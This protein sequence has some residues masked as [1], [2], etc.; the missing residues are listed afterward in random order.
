M[1]ITY[2]QESVVT[3]MNQVEALAKLEWEEVQHNKEER[4][5]SPDWDLYML[6]EDKGYLMIFTV[7]DSGKLVGYF[8][9]TISPNLHCKGD[10]VVANDAIFLHPDYRKSRIGV[11]LFKFT[12][13]CLA[14]SGYNFLYVSTTERNKIDGL[15]SYLGYEKV[16][17]RFLKRIGREDAH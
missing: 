16:E 10:F 2:Q 4:T 7:R 6:L 3:V 8:F 11:N 9:A 12:E 17:T 15:M 5:L 14:E 13:K 1:P